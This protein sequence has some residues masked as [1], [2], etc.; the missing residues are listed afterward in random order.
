MISQKNALLFTAVT[1][2][3]YGLQF[4]PELPSTSTTRANAVQRIELRST[5]FPIATGD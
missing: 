1:G 5:K 3:G 4:M 2:F